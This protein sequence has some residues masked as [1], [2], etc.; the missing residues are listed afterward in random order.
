M[1]RMKESIRTRRQGRWEEGKGKNLEKEDET[2]ASGGLFTGRNRRVLTSRIKETAR[3]LNS[4]IC[5]L[6]FLIIKLL[7]R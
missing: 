1:K 4:T 6:I 2:E 7:A 5:I 3:H